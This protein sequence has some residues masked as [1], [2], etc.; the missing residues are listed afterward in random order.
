MI[1]NSSVRLFSGRDL[2]RVGEIR[3][4][5]SDGR[6][7]VSTRTLNLRLLLSLLYP[8]SRVEEI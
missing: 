3:V 6:G 1:F 7:G 8:I 5:K 2:R 4:S